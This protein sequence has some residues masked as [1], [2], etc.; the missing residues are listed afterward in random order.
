MRLLL[1]FAA[2]G[3]MAA[4]CW[5]NDGHKPGIP[6]TRDYPVA[7]TTWSAIVKAAGDKAGTVSKWS[8]N[9]CDSW[10][11]SVQA[12]IR[13]KNYEPTICYSNTCAWTGSWKSIVKL[14]DHGCG[15][16]YVGWGSYD[17]TCLHNTKNLHYRN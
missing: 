17:N 12:A 14:E 4:D 6:E 8:N 16:Y 13:N 2:S 11:K 9:D 10:V 3:A 5:D 7:G 1:L 15:E